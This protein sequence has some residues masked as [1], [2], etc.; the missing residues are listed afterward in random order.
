MT[1]GFRTF[2]NV[3]KW[4]ISPGSPK[5]WVKFCD[6][7]AITNNDFSSGDPVFGQTLTFTSL[8]QAVLDD[9]NNIPTSFVRLYDADT[10]PTFAT[11]NSTNLIIKV[12]FGTAPL[13]HGGWTTRRVQGGLAVEADITLS[14]AVKSSARSFTATFTHEL[15]HALGLDHPQET[16]FSIMSYFRSVNRLQP[17]DKMGITYIYPTDPAYAQETPTFGMSCSGK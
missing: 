14:T 10:D 17:D 13:G 16:N 3:A 8:T 1:L 9:Y 2:P 4:N 5:L 11:S 7:P 12:C 6:R 15:G